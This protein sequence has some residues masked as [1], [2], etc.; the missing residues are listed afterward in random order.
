[1]KARY[2][3]III[4]VHLA[5]SGFSQASQPS[6]NIVVELQDDIY[7]YDRSNDLWLPFTADSLSSTLLGIQLS[8]QKYRS[9][10]L[11]LYTPGKTSIY[12]DQKMIAYKSDEG[13]YFWSLDS[14]SKIY[15]REELFISFYNQDGLSPKQII[16]NLCA[17]VEWQEA[18]AQLLEGSRELTSLGDFFV[19]SFFL[20]LAYFAVAYQRFP[21]FFKEFFSLST[22]FSLRIKKEENL[23]SSRPINPINL[24]FLIGYSLMISWL[25]MLSIY[26]YYNTLLEMS[27]NRNFLYYASFWLLIALCILILLHLKFFSIWMLSQ[28]FDLGKFRNSHFIDFIGMSM[29]FFGIVF[30][31]SGSTLLGWRYA[32]NDVLAVLLNSTMLFL[33]LR[34]LILFFKSLSVSNFQKLHLF[35]YLC[36]SELVPALILIKV[37]GF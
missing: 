36:T 2:L 22:M 35:S 7:A 30:L 9:L 5:L 15:S 4:L 13:F 31:L 26:Y 25:L 3:L 27:I 6:C 18:G 23:L 29:I 34:V 20:I 19:V 17:N 24:F 21:D 12:I 11:Q 37:M 10:D 8:I 16:L 32:L 28:L 1:M 33:L 14:L